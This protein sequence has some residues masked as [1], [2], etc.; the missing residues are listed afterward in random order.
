MGLHVRLVD[1]A[2][3]GEIGGSV[4]GVVVYEDDV[5]VAGWLEEGEEG[6]VLEGF[7]S[8]DEGEVF[9]GGDEGGVG[10]VVEG[11]WV[12]GVLVHGG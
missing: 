8:V 5:Y 6:V 1:F 9:L 4:G 11:V 10:V 7:A 3:V 12:D 2:S